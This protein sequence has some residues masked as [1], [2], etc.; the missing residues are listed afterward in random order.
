MSPSSS[1]V[2]VPGEPALAGP[3]PSRQPLAAEALGYLGAVMALIAGVIA[4]RQL[5]PAVPAVAELAF[6]AAA[7]TGLLLA[8][9]VIRADRHPALARLRS[10]VWLASSVA[11]ADV[12]RLA[13]GPQFWDLGRTGAPL[14]AEAVVA[15]YAV[16]LWWRSSSAVSQVAA[17]TAV[18]ALTG[19]AITLPWPG[20]PE[21]AP[22][23]GIW[24]VALLWGVAAHRG[25]LAPQGTGYAVAA[26]GLLIGAQLAIDAG[27][28]QV[29]AVVTVAGLLAA[30]VAARRE[31]L[32][33]LG[34]LGAAVLLP[35]VAILYLP[36]GATPAVAVCAAGLAMLGAA[37]WLGRRRRQAR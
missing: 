20:A 8:G 1:P 4:I 5:W 14:I 12:M 37:I 23:A 17:F 35:Q 31:I 15:A 9:L 18:L 33:A 22:G 36:G 10:V 11:L 30:G 19:T 24:A 7:A 29:L 27:A 2:S 25:L 6:A 3:A 32:L 34:A 13:T 28:G 26:A 21:W 16:A